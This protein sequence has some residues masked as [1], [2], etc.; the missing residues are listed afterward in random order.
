MAILIS[1]DPAL[2]IYDPVKNTKD[3]NPEALSKADKQ[4]GKKL[5]SLGCYHVLITGVDEQNFQDAASK[6][7]SQGDIMLSLSS[8][9]SP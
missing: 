4:L 7:V 1:L 5:L 8:A 3:S 6:E 9:V 2:S